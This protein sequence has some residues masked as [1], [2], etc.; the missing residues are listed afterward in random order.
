MKLV[1]KKSKEELQYALS[2]E[3]FV[4]KTCS[5]YVYKK[6]KKRSDLR[7]E[8]FSTLK[9]LNI[10]GRVYVSEEGINAQISVPETNLKKFEKKIKENIFFKNV[11]FNYAVE[12]G[13]SFFKLT[14]KLKEQIVAYGVKKNEYDMNKVGQHLEPED[15]HKKIDEDKTIVVDVR[16]YYESEI[17][18]FKNAFCPDVRRSNEIL[19]AIKEKL[20]GKEDYKILMY[21]TGG[22]RCEKASS[23]LIKNNFK[24][25]YQLKS[26]IINYA[27]YVK[28]NNKTS[29]F[30]GKNYVFDHRLGERVTK[31]VLSKCHQCE[32]SSDEH[33]NCANDLCHML[34][35]QCKNCQKKYEKCC[36]KECLEY[37]KLNEEIKEKKKT[38]FVRYI[39]KR[40]KGLV[41]PKLKEIKKTL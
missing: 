40:N 27:H 39:K 12:E 14:V 22:I 8:I 35:I 20:K 34:F 28:N 19:P 41:K 26:G 9:K 18:K 25:V 23:Y 16:N 37:L 15:F 24:N 32:E 11:N 13:V 3:K 33:V 2:K 17:G 36:S 5:F 30:I 1:N 7:D 29:K 21:C 38:S 10:L 4:R 31:D 6:I